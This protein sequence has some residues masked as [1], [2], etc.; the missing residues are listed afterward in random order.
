[1]VQHTHHSK[2][3][4]VRVVQVIQKLCK[5]QVCNALEE[6]AIIVRYV[7]LRHHGNQ[8]KPNK[9]ATLIHFNSSSAETLKCPSILLVYKKKNLKDAT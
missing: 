9:Q 1:M 3:I 8:G 7:S 5:L 2:E 6:E 4:S